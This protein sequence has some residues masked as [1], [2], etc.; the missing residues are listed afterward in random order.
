MKSAMK[1]TLKGFP[2]AVMRLKGPCHLLKA[3]PPSNR[4][5][6]QCRWDCIKKALSLFFIGES[7]ATPGV[8]FWRQKKTG[9]LF[10]A[11]VGNGNLFLIEKKMEH[12]QIRT[13]SA[14]SRSS[15]SPCSV[16]GSKSPAPAV[17]LRCSTAP[18]TPCRRSASHTAPARGATLPAPLRQPEA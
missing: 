18:G 14:G 11:H 15:S 7:A 9:F 13:S 12:F 2:I 4:N 17:R 1:Y 3:E 6:Q 16:C 10:P 8:S 5:G